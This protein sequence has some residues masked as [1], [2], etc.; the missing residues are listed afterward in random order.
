MVGE[1][2]DGRFLPMVHFYITGGW[3]SITTDFHSVPLFH[4]RRLMRE[5]KLTS[6]LDGGLHTRAYPDRNG[7][8]V[9]QCLLIDSRCITFSF[10]LWRL[11]LGRRTR[12][13][14]HLAVERPRERRMSLVTC[15]TGGQTG[16]AVSFSVDSVGSVGNLQ[17][18][19]NNFKRDSR[20]KFLD[21]LD[22]YFK[23]RLLAGSRDKVVLGCEERRG[24]VWV[25]AV[26]SEGPGEIFLFKEITSQET[27]DEHSSI[28]SIYFHWLLVVDRKWGRCSLY[29]SG[30]LVFPENCDR[31][32]IKSNLQMNTQWK[33]WPRFVRFSC[34]SIFLKLCIFL[35]FSP[36]HRWRLTRR[37][38]WRRS[39]HGVSGRAWLLCH[40]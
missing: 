12:V 34:R 23:S 24:T 2:V 6:L 20:W 39:G 14:R 30:M 7:T 16:E 33:I 40:G 11:R 5:T 13:V 37:G 1:L 36:Y 28:T 31:E 27:L 25:P 35:E 22:I 10:K 26:S 9:P 4:S 3:V 32:D 15:C 29:L 8:L 19:G 21:Y 17:L 18:Y 38:R